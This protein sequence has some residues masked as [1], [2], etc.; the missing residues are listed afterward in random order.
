[1]GDRQDAAFRSGKRFT[2]LD[3]APYMCQS[4]LPASN[5]AGEPPHGWLQAAF[6]Q[7]HTLKIRDSFP[8]F[9]DPLHFE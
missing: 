5:P 7:L 8:S 4:K 3:S 1:M 6:Q 2:R 9:V